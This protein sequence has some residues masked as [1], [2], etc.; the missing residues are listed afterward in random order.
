MHIDLSAFDYKRG[1]MGR[2]GGGGGGCTNS[3]RYC[4]MKGDWGNRIVASGP[5]GPNSQ[6]LKERERE[7]D[8]ERQRE[9]QRDRERDRERE[10]GERERDS[11]REEEEEGGVVRTEIQ[12]RSLS[13]PRPV[14]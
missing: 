1:G 4:V 13:I 10:E 14:C 2:G 7:T 8:R 9:R 3:V 5:F 12:T 6:S 11:E